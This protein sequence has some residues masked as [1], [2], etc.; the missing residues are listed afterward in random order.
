MYKFENNSLP[1][2]FDNYFTKLK[3]KKKL[4]EKNNSQE[5][6]VTTGGSGLVSQIKITYRDFLKRLKICYIYFTFMAS[7]MQNLSLICCNKYDSSHSCYSLLE[8][9]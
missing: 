9:F 7:A 5:V 8:V 4:R 6:I 3:K 1:I 2:F